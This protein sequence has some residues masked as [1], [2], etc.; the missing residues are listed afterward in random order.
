M[1]ELGT[2]APHF[3]LPEPRTGN[4]LTLSDVR[5]PNGL[6]VVFMC[7]HC[8][9]VIML[10]HQLRLLG[11]HLATLNIG[12]VGISS[13]DIQMHPQDGPVE[14]AHM[15]NTVFTS[16][17]YLLDETQNVA[18]AYHAACTPDTF[19]YDA[20]M[21]LVYRYVL[22]TFNTFNL[23]ITSYLHIVFIAHSFSFLVTRTQGPDRRCTPRK[24]HRSHGQL[25]SRCSTLIVNETAHPGTFHETRHR[26][27]H[28]MEELK[29]KQP[30]PMVQPTIH[31]T[32]PN[33]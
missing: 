14:M 16:F 27:Q 19:L 24:W 18:K 1:R 32:L 30:I 2:P 15:A 13:N 9:F 17:P 33:H 3:A 11:E 12:M 22:P 25:R 28:K 5:K 31:F 10:Q 29:K 23:Y 21:N 20:D 8:P 26:M 7:N 6:L 4:T